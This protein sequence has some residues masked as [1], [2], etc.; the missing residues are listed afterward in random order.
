MSTVTFYY[1]QEKEIIVKLSISFITLKE[2][3]LSLDNDWMKWNDKNFSK[4]LMYPSINLYSVSIILIDIKGQFQYT[5]VVSKFPF[6]NENSHHIWKLN[7]KFA[8][9]FENQSWRL[10]PEESIVWQICQWCTG[11]INQPVNLIHILLSNNL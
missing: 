4:L 1:N 7:T 6:H 10:S 8:D 11:T 5:S 9:T 2:I 3:K